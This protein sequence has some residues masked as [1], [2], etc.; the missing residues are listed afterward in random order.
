VALGEALEEGWVE[1]EAAV[2]EWDDWGGLKGLFTFI[3]CDIV[4]MPGSE[5]C[6][7]RKAHRQEC[8]CH[9]K[10]KS[11]QDAGA[12]RDEKRNSKGDWFKRGGLLFS[13]RL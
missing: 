13:G 2:S 4:R 12:T 5:G 1:Y 9:S 7:V 8:L 6:R 3:E 11:Q 10:Q